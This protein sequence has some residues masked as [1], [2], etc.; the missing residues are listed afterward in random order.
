MIQ[1]ASKDYAKIWV[2]FLTPLSS[3][4]PDRV[5]IGIKPYPY[6]VTRETLQSI[7]NLFSKNE[8]PV[9]RITNSRG[10]NYRNC[11]VVVTSYEKR[12]EEKDL[13]NI[14]V[15]STVI[16]TGHLACCKK[17]RR[18]GD[19]ADGIELIDPKEFIDIKHDLYNQVLYDRDNCD[20]SFN[21]D[22]SVH[23]VQ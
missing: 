14:N 4:S 15:L 22:I 7:T 17:V 6:L 12:C 3:N 20:L 9:L 11:E 21:T 16:F 1:N 2:R 10:Y 18:S 23:D 5:R 19:S 8:N 13:E